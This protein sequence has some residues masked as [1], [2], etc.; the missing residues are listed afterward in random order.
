MES[1]N[2]LISHVQYVL[3]QPNVRYLSAHSIDRYLSGNSINLNIGLFFA[4][5][6]LSGIQ[7]SRTPVLSQTSTITVFPIHKDQVIS[8]ITINSVIVVQLR[9][10]QEGVLAET[11]LEGVYEYG[12]GVNDIQAIEDLVIS[13]NEYILFLNANK[14][15]LGDSA[16]RELVAL[17][18][19]IG[20]Q[21]SDHSGGH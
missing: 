3:Q 14:D 1:T 8:G 7:N 19:L 16:K 9:P 5:I 12:V 13:L 21:A 18:R 20:A 4:D 17:Q 15:T 6:T 2:E 10:T 11:W